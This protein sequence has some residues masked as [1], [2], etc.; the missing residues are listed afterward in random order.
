[1]RQFDSLHQTGS[2]TEY[3]EKLEQLSHNIL[4]YNNSYD[5]VY[6]VTRFVGGLKEEIRAAI[7]LHHPQDV[8]TASALAL[9]QE[10]ELE[11]S[12][13]KSFNKDF[14]K[15]VSKGFSDPDKPKFGFKKDDHKKQ[16]KGP[17]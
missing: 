10:H 12:M 9:L 13:K 4:L 6:F 14:G 16:D 3:Y 2:V 17:G 5:D 1:M 15:G 7:T 11:I 8:D